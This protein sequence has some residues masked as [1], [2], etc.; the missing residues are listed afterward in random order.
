MNHYL[1]SSICFG[2]RKSCGRPQTLSERDERHIVIVA[3]NST[4]SCATIQRELALNVNRN[5]AW[6]T[7]ERNEHIV[8]PEM[9]RTPP[10]RVQH[11]V[12]RVAFARTDMSQG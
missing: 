6:G 4:K 5:T 11:K 2:T 1:N 9:A 12:Y 3:S 8:R 10:L 7:L